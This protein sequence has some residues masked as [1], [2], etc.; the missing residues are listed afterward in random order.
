V[1]D[2]T[3]I[4]A[5][6]RSLEAL[7]P[8]RT[9][10]QR[11]TRTS[12]EGLLTTIREQYGGF[13]TIDSPYDFETGIETEK[14]TV[15]E[16]I[17]SLIADEGTV[18]FLRAGYDFDNVTHMMKARLLRGT[19]TL[20]TYGLVDPETV[21]NAVEGGEWSLLPGHLKE[22]GAMLER[23]GEEHGVSAVEYGGESEKW[24]FLLDAAPAPSGRD[25]I[26]WKIDCA[27]IKN[28][29]RLKRIPLRTGNP[30]DVWIGGGELDTGRLSTL[31][32][33]PEG[34]LYSVLAYTGYRG[35]VGLGLSI[36]APLWKIDT[37]L[38]RFL[39][40]LLG[41]S[42]YRF[43][44]LSPVL[45]HLE[46]VDRNMRLLRMI[47]SGTLNRMPEEMVTGR[48]DTLLPA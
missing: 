6:L 32:R 8:D 16:L 40:D 33:E 36:E 37:L 44:D 34:E 15:L 25:Y 24:R 21:M 29:I 28:F 5:R 26:R 22:Y 47:V 13:E 14:A 10:F 45:Y 19:P 11:L 3:Y 41:E 48:V 18:T 17:S 42:R 23:V 46:L 4:I 39:L 12:E 30:E 43:F 1:Q 35:L 9:W 27:N 2:Y 31:F 7:M 38:D 20:S